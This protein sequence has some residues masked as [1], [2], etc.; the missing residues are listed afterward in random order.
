MRFYYFFL[1]NTKEKMDQY[2]QIQNNIEIK[3]IKVNDKE[4]K[5]GDN[6]KDTRVYF[7]IKG[8]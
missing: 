6:D 1:S 4:K 3:K 7:N 5:V 8:S 2:C